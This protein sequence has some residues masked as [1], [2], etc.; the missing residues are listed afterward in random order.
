MEKNFK[1]TLS[2]DG[3]R[4]KGWQRL[5][6]TDN[7]IQGKLEDLLSRLFGQPVEVTGAGRT[8]AGVHAAGQVANFHI[9]TDMQAA[10]LCRRLRHM[11]PPDIGLIQAEEVPARFHSRLS[12]LEKTYCYRVWNSEVPNVFLQRYT[13]QL[14]GPLNLEAMQAAAACFTGTHDFRA[15]CSGRYAEKSTTRTITR[16]TVERQGDE[17][18]MTV[19]GDGFL[20]NMVRILAGTL[21]EIGQ[22]RRDTAEIPALL[23][24]RTRSNAGE[25]APARGL[26]LMEVR[27]E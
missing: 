19:S 10:D 18:R 4:W 6:T 13:Y 16:F 12:A 24:S 21:L 8:D 5:K 26:C 23:E 14:P 7:T 1:L 11:L 3:T 15:F 25:T 9:N 20:Y 17:I 2:Y 22:G 27:Y